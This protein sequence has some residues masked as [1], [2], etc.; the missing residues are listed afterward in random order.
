[1]ISKAHYQA[2]AHNVPLFASKFTLGS[3]EHN[4]GLLSDTLTEFIP[5]NCGF[6]VIRLQRAQC[7]F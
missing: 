3:G 1:M 5:S 4:K 6:E 2:L 7:I